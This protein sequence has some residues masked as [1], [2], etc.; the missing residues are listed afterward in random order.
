MGIAAA[1]GDPAPGAAWIESHLNQLQGPGDLERTILALSAAHAPLGV[2]VAHLE[3]DQSRDGSF[4]EQ[5]N[6]TAFA[7]LALRAADTSRAGIARATTWLVRQENSDGGFGFA[8]RGSPSDVDDTAAAVQALTPRASVTRALAYL[9]RAEN[10]DG[11]FPQT[12][13]GPS[14]AQ[15]TAW[16]L[17]AFLATGR[18]PLGTRYL[19]RLTTRSGEVDYSTGVAQTPVWVTAQALAA[20]AG[21]AL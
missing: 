4:S 9:R 8:Q 7:I 15:S 11:G 12:P 14:D 6:L 2:L 18:P 19:E 20:L 17:Q 3:H 1:G 5:S 13:A 16:A 10:R 21:H